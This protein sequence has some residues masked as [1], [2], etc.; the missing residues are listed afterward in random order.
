MTVSAQSAILPE[1]SK[2]PWSLKF[3]LFFLVVS[4]ISL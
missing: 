2:I 1:L 4:P 3:P